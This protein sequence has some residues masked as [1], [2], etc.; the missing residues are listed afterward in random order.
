MN[1][2]LQTN[3][4]FEAFFFT[5][6]LKIHTFIRMDNSIEENFHRNMRYD[7]FQGIPINVTSVICQF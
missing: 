6:F 3:E 1:V 7:K 2:P 4:K 5:E